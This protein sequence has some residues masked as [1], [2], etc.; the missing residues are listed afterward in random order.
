MKKA[1][2]DGL[3]D[4]TL[5][6]EE[7]LPDKNYQVIKRGGT[8]EDLIEF[9]RSSTSTNRLELWSKAHAETA[10]GFCPLAIRAAGSPR[11]QVSATC[12]MFLLS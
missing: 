9:M 5:F 12:R 7:T 1:I 8:A 6:V 4:P 11:I 2:G 3:S 10:K